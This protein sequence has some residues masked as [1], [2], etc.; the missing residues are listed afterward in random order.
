MHTEQ[1]RVK[2]STLEAIRGLLQQRRGHEGLSE[3]GRTD[4]GGDGSGGEGAAARVAAATARQATAK[5]RRRARSIAARYAA[6]RGAGGQNEAV[7]SSVDSVDVMCPV[8]SSVDV[9]CPAIVVVG[10]TSVG[11]ELSARH[12]VLHTL[13]NAHTNQCTH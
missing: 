1:V 7:E 12:I 9:M 11:V 6:T 5:T 8:E 4:G 13:I 2:V 10:T 3:S